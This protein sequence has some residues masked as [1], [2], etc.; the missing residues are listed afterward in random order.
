MATA[1]VA[2]AVIQFVLQAGSKILWSSL[3]FLHTLFLWAF[4]LDADCL[5]HHPRPHPPCPHTT[6]PG[7]HKPWHRYKWSRGQHLSKIDVSGDEKC[8]VCC[9]VNSCLRA[10][11]SN[12]RACSV[13]IHTHA[14]QRH[15]AAEATTT[16]HSHGASGSHTHTTLTCH[17]AAEATSTPHFNETQCARC[18]R[19]HARVIPQVRCSVMQHE[20][21]KYI[22]SQREDVLTTR[23]F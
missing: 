18:T 15:A 8:C 5:I 19:M 7:P 2:A 16:P 11:V 12:T 9:A 22:W 14:V 13:R 4:G 10:P 21:A 17:A 3:D 6:C 23:N 1:A 20:A